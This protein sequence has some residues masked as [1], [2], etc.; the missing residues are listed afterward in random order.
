[1]TKI[2]V[3]ALVTCAVMCS[4]VVRGENSKNQYWLFHPTPRDRMREL[5][6]DRPDKTESPHTVDAGHFQME[7][8]VISYSFDRRKPDHSGK[9]THGFAI[10]P[11]LLKLGLTNFMDFHVSIEPYVSNF[12]YNF[13]TGTTQNSDGFGDVV[14]RAKIALAGNDSGKFALAT[15]PYVAIP[16]TK[17]DAIGDDH[18][19]GGLFFPWS[20]ELPKRW[21]I[22]GQTQLDWAYN[23][24][25]SGYHV[26]YLNTL[27]LAYSISGRFGS[28]VEFYAQ[29]SQE[30]G[31]P[32]VG[33][34]DTGLTFAATD[35]LLLDTGINFGV[36]RAANDVNPFAGFTWRH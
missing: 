17:N 10:M 35:S 29:V 18:V 8:S 5:S 30:T 25:S 20:L 1:M 13:A 3:V 21:E 9:S 16:T 27:E 7:S 28:Y 36:T 2:R 22:A 11:S 19:H 31:V 34:V 4:G 6:A 26:E 32:W 24:D 15:M 14:L 23:I 12:S 33:T